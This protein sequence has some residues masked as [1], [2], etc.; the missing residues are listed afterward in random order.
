MRPAIVIGWIV[1]PRHVAPRALHMEAQNYPLHMIQGYELGFSDAM[2]FLTDVV[3]A[4]DQKDPAYAAISKSRR[5]LLPFGAVAL[6]ETI[7]IMRPSRVFFSAQGVREGYLYSLLPDREKAR[8]PLLSAADAQLYLAKRAGR[9]C[10]RC[11]APPNLFPAPSAVMM[12][13]RRRAV[14]FA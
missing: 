4:K 6:Q 13:G 7:A 12:D 5:N 9:D 3:T 1:H 14:K 11:D 2:D 10:Y 8:D